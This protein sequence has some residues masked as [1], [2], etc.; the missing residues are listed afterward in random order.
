[1]QQ[2][3]NSESVD[4]PS[5]KHHSQPD[6]EK[7]YGALMGLF[8]AKSS[9]YDYQE[10]RQRTVDTDLWRSPYM[11]YICNVCMQQ[12][13]CISGRACRVRGS[14]SPQG[15][16]GGNSQGKP[17]PTCGMTGSR[18]Q[19]GVCLKEYIPMSVSQ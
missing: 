10:A 12:Q 11:S 3:N 4:S 5:P 2:G 7:K 9:T 15:L 13:G 18:V 1:M 19:G 8:A 14:S 17:K 6:V 16:R